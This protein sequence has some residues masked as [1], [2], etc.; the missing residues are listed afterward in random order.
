MI[1]PV[2]REIHAESVCPLLVK[3]TTD[4]VTADGLVQIKVVSSLISLLEI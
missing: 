1:S 4:V 2:Y 3:T